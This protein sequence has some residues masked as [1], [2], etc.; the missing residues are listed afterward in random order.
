[1][2]YA[3]GKAEWQTEGRQ[4]E[5]SAVE[6]I[7]EIKVG[8]AQW[9][10]ARLHDLSVSGFRMG[11]MRQG[12]GGSDVRIRIPGL[13]PLSAAVRWRDKT[14]LGCEFTRPLNPYVLQHILRVASSTYARN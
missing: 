4:D 7:A 2:S 1:M 10:M 12:P 3:Y 14:V 8:F 9:Q 6:I 5:R 11:P 13:E